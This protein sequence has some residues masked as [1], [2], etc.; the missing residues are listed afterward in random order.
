MRLT[1]SVVAVL[2]ALLLDACPRQSTEDDAG[3]GDVDAG[4]DPAVGNL[5]TGDI[6]LD[7]ARVMSVDPATLRAG[8]T[9]CRAPLLARVT[10]VVDGDTMHVTGI[11]ETLPD[12]DIRFIGV[13]APEIAHMAGDPTDCYG[14]EATLFTHQLNGHLV[15]LT[16]DEGCLDP[17]SRLL[18]YVFIGPGDGDMWQRQ[19]VR[20]GFAHAVEFPPN[21]MY[22]GV[23]DAD[24][25][26]AESEGVG[27][28]S[29]CP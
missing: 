2:C 6:L 27:L 16:F 29:A 12:A 23:L 8:G 28:W 19:L 14:D 4:Y 20:R 25:A 26:I 9:P 5:F 18:A 11:S 13:N 21:L 7:D 17:Y 22:A 15:W 10:R 24:M 1:L 3:G